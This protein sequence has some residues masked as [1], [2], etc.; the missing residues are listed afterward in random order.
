[1]V[2]ER[3]STILE[4]RCGLSLGE[5]LLVGV[6]GGPDSLALLDALVVI[7]HSVVVAHYDHGLREEAHEE[8]EFV[9][10]IA[11]EWNL[12]FIFESGDTQ[13]YASLHHLSIEEAARELRYEFLFRVA[14]SQKASA[15]LVGH[16]ADDQAETV[17]MHLL[18][19]AG[20]DG[21]SG[22]D[23]RV[24]SGW[25]AEIPLVRPLLSTWREEILDY[26]QQR[27]L[28]PRFDR[29][30]WDRTH[31]RNRLRHELIPT[32]EGYNP[33]IKSL[34]WKMSETI[35]GDLGV[36]DG[37]VD[38]LMVDM[39]LEH[40]QRSIEINR[41]AFSGCK[42]GIQRRILRRVV[43]LLRPGLKDIGYDAIERIISLLVDPP[44]SRRSDLIAGLKL[45]IEEDRFILADW[46]VIPSRSDWPQ[47][48]PGIE[49]VLSVPGSV[50][51]GNDWVFTAEIDD[52]TRENSSL[53][54]AKHDLFT[55]Y[56]DVAACGDSLVIRGRKPGDR[57][58]PLGMEG[59]SAKISDFMINVKLPRRAR[60]RW[61]LV[62][63]QDNLIWVPGYQ[64][65]EN[66]KVVE[67]TE[68]VI[69]L[70]LARKSS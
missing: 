30:N 68:M 18:R 12:P 69:R 49:F 31:F 5:T 35:T 39:L 26:C 59:S 19:G 25:S 58:K 33:N 13:H 60:P 51:I 23:Y 24:I 52:S 17:V 62:F 22:M 54:E 61:P 50:E 2:T 55:A 15:V 45:E 70:H 3:L 6:S 14:N 7:G 16:N 67:K 57:F 63:S 28:K 64:I 41:A 1:M 42:I 47:L 38:E 46:N 37:V 8:L 32:L 21:L 53:W 48:G 20:L 4:R 44:Q 10:R 36:L 9:Q 56:F 66:A 40:R 65:A 34:I 27:D 29:S 11:K 43:S